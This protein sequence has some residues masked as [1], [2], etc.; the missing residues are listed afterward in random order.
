MW[1]IVGRCYHC[2]QL[3]KRQA[4]L[5]K[6]SAGIMGRAKLGGASQLPQAGLVYVEGYST[7]RLSV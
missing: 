7:H 2:R 4:R 1:K 3:Q 6:S 5:Q